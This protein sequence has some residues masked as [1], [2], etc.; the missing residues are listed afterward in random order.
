[1][2]INKPRYAF[3]N[4]TPPPFNTIEDGYVFTVPNTS[5]KNFALGHAGDRRHVL[6]VGPNNGNTNGNVNVNLYDTYNYSNVTNRIPVTVGSKLIRA[7][8]NTGFSNHSTYRNYYASV[9][10]TTVDSSDMQME[11]GYYD[12][13]SNTFKSTV[14]TKAQFWTPPFPAYNP[15]TLV[16]SF[17]RGYPYFI[18]C[19]GKVFVF[20][21]FAYVVNASNHTYSQYRVFEIG[22]EGEVTFVQ[23]LASSLGNYP[24]TLV[25]ISGV[26]RRVALYTPTVRGN[27][28]IINSF[29]SPTLSNSSPQSGYIQTFV[30]NGTTFV[31]QYGEYTR[32][33][34]TGFL[35]AFERG[36]SIVSVH[37]GTDGVGPARLVY[38]HGASALT[39]LLSTVAPN[40]TLALDL[41]TNFTFSAVGGE[42]KIRLFNSNNTFTDVGT[43]T[44]SQIDAFDP[45]MFGTAVGSTGNL[46]VHDNAIIL[47]GNVTIGGRLAR[48]LVLGTVS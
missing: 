17:Q 43:I 41:V 11:A 29:L 47:N 4:S 39:E 14:L 38:S 40:E 22:P 13:A 8:A 31:P 37:Y 48:A 3:S 7:N 15:P 32:L 25:N 45:G 33:Q 35:Y 12:F 44:A 30:Y 1:M 28:V 19:A 23:D 24:N 9:T 46:W 5:G 16:G 20:V 42:C 21:Y 27:T 18:E 6:F 10:A 26:N 36:G 34:S 2:L